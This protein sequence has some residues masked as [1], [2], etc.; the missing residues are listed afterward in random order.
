[1]LISDADLYY[2]DEPTNG[3]DPEMLIILRGIINDL[4]N[5]RKTVIINSHNLE[6]IQEVTSNVLIINEGR[7]TFNGVIDNI[8]INKLYMEKAGESGE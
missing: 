8:D 2:F 1:M 3:L 7:I 5:Q 6:F 4:N